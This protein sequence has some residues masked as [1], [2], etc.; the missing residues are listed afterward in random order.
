MEVLDFKTTAWQ[1]APLE[2]GAVALWWLG[3][4][5]FAV[6]FGRR[7]FLIDPYLSDSLAV[8]YRDAE[9]K[10]VR[11]M[12]PPIAPRAVRRLDWVFCTHRHGDHMDPG[13][14]GVLARNN[15][16]GFFLPAAAGEHAVDV[17]GLDGERITALRAGQT[18]PLDPRVRV[19]A[20]PSA[21]EQLVVNE[22][23]EHL[24]LGLVFCLGG[25]TVYHAGDCCPYDGLAEALREHRVD[26]A[27]LPVNGRDT[28]RAARKVPGNFHFAEAL[29]L[30]RDLDIPWM[31]PHHFG[32]FEFNTVDPENLRR[33]IDASQTRPAV[34]IPQIDRAMVFGGR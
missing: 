31:I 18:V 15:A 14:L 5:G 32:M 4:A 19:T 12:P 28:V 9:Y 33:Q 10:H 11:M 7:G 17:V 30:C 26:V 3:Q 13:T 2:E 23:G 27:L 6:R 16:C 29:A 25:L 24:F 1:D 20:I 21:H 8:K 34:C 22:A